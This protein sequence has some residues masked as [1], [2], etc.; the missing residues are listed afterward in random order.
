MKIVENQKIY[1]C[2]FCNKKHYK[3]NIISLHERQCRNNPKNKHKCFQYCKFLDKIYD[4]CEEN[5]FDRL[6]EF[7]CK[8]E[9]CGFY[10]KPLY[11]FKYERFHSNKIRIEENDLIRMPLDCA[12]YILDENHKDYNFETAKIFKLQVD[13]NC[14]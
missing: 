12:Y 14:L 8:N 4:P 3:K 1:C 2:E 10:E 11:S 9:K 6:I 13:S 5:G 7:S